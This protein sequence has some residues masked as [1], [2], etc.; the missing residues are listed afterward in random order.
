[1]NQ[2]PYQAPAV[3]SCTAVRKA[4]LR[5]DGKCLVV[6]SGVVLPRFCVKTNAALEP[7][8]LKQRRLSWCPPWVALW[9]LA[10]VLILVLVYFMVRKQC[11][12]TFG[13]SPAV[14]TKYRNRFLFKIISVIVL[15][16]AI[17]FSAAFDSPVAIVTVVI[18]F[19]V[20]VVSLLIGNAPLTITQHRVGEF[21][22][23]GCSKEFL[24]RM[25]DVAEE[26]LPMSEGGFSQITANFHR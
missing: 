18:L 19:L 20:A 9:I 15:F 7:Q 8:D 17:P 4:Q 16:V 23:S 10:N 6:P 25:Q 14:R 12:I 3:D 1:M 2:N 13:L 5:V 21:W 26:S 24:L 11:V 22:I